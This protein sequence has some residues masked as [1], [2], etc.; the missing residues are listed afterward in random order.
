MAIARLKWI[1]RIEKGAHGRV[2]SA[3]AQP[4]DSASKEAGWDICLE[5]YLSADHSLS[6]LLH[7]ISK[8]RYVGSFDEL[9]AESS[10]G[11]ARVHHCAHVAQRHS[12]PACRAPLT[13]VAAGGPREQP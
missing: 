9:P 2:V 10:S 6:V 11:S 5:I 12:A 7:H 8:G 4:R 1:E 13:L 3:Q